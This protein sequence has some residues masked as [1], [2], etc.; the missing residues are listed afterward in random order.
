MIQGLYAAA[1]GMMGIERLQDVVANNIA[2]AT[3]P[4]F[5]RQEMVQEGFDQV[6]FKAMRDPF[7]F[8]RE[9]G[10]GGGLRPWS[11]F[12]DLK[13]GPLQDTGNPLNVAIEGPGFFAVDTPEGPRYTRN[14]QFTVGVDGQLVTTEGF[15][16]SGGIDVGEGKV[17]IDNEGNVIVDGTVAG[18]LSIVEFEDPRRL[19][20]AGDDFYIA[21]QEVEGESAPATQ[22]SVV[23]GMVEQSNVQLPMEMVNMTLGLRHYAAN[24]RVINAM[25]E[26]MGRVIDQVGFPQ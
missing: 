17:E 6:F 26:T 18:Q 9:A 15:K 16:V 22:S 8:N 11:T 2:N 1:T 13:P 3:T 24:Q 4:G 21:S 10:P 25:D 19:T 20:R 5:R 14:G 12:T 23:S 7:F